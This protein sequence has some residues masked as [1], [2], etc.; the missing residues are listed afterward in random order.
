MNDY[1]KRDLYKELF[2]CT[3]ERQAAKP[4]FLGCMAQIKE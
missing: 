2:Y 4:D 3:F 1:R